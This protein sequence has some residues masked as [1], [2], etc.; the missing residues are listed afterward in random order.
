MHLVTVRIESGTQVKTSAGR[1]QGDEIAL[2]DAPDVKA[3]LRAGPVTGGRLPVPET[4]ARIA[5]ADADLASVVPTPEKIV[6]VGMNYEDHIAEIGTE[7]P[8]APTYFAKYSRALV[9]PRDPILMPD[10]EM[11]DKVDWE[12]E[13]AVVIGRPVRRASPTEALA[14]I[15]GFAV[16]NDVSVRDWQA[17]S[18][19]FL[20]GKTFEQST[21]LGPAL[22]TADESGDGVGLALGC[23][24]N[25]VVKQAGNT[26][27]M[28]FQPAQ[29]VADLS[30]ILT[31]DP[32][33]VIATGTPGG[34]G[35]YRT[36]QEWL[37][38]GDVIRTWIEGL[39][40]LLNTCAAPC[41]RTPYSQA[42]Y[43]RAP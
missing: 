33:D 37:K 27:D 4:G 5:L 40:E 18:T 31:L 42:P 12:V 32:G 43:S 16:L 28:V 14:A 35:A 23:D 24:V 20:A 38:P 9:G 3:L 30:R 11:S 10:P 6:C 26:S 22:V 39:G 7:K 17:R 25:G 2:L 34:V 21:P 8:E 13:L 29:L 36:P 15:A 41:T 1:I 19:Q